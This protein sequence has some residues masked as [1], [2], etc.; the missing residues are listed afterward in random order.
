MKKMIL[1]GMKRLFLNDEPPKPL[2]SS[3]LVNSARKNTENQTNT[4]RKRYKVLSN[5]T[6]KVQN[7]FG[8]PK[9]EKNRRKSA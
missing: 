3:N 2:K 1:S 4:K 8:M 6:E 7:S 5:G 9:N